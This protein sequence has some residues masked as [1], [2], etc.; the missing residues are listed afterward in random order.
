MSRRLDV[1]AAAFWR[2]QRRAGC[3]QRPDGARQGRRARGAA[4]RRFPDIPVLA[5]EWEGSAHR[6]RSGLTRRRSSSGCKAHPAIAPAGSNRGRHG[7]DEMSEAPYTGST[8]RAR[9]GIRNPSRKLTPGEERP[10]YWVLTTTL[11]FNF[12]SVRRI[13]TAKTA[14]PQKRGGQSRPVAERGDSGRGIP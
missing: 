8:A 14:L 10:I 1:G 11:S 2:R 3:S 9:A 7:N 4:W 6:R 5:P 13:V 12:C